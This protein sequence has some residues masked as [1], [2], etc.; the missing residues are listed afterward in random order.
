MYPWLSLT[1]RTEKHPWS[2]DRQREND[3]PRQTCVPLH[4]ND[5][6]S[7]VRPSVTQ[8]YPAANSTSVMD[9]GRDALLGRQAP[10]P[11][12]APM[13]GCRHL[14]PQHLAVRSHPP[15]DRRLHLRRRILASNTV[16]GKLPSSI[17][18]FAVPAHGAYAIAMPD[19]H[20]FRRLSRLTSRKHVLL[21]GDRVKR[22]HGRDQ[23]IPLYLHHTVAGGSPAVDPASCRRVFEK[24]CNFSPALRPCNTGQKRTFACLDRRPAVLQPQFASLRRNIDGSLEIGP[25]SR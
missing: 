18:F 20:S 1:N 11:W 25:Q 23:V 6:M 19:K 15:R 5:S 4:P 21:R 24:S 3:C 14:D 7:A 12:H 17:H 8:C 22:G 16:F 9:G 2:I 10:G 13:P